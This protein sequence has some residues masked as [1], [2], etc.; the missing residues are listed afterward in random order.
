MHIV[1][2]P[3]LCP[4]TFW[5]LAFVWSVIQGCAGRWYGLYIYDSNAIDKYVRPKYVRHFAYG[6]HHGAFYFLCSFAGFIAWCLAAQFAA[7][8]GETEGAWLTISGGSGTIL[9][10]LAVLGLLGVSGALPRVLYL[11]NRPV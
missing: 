11:G 3:M 4:K 7:K 10:A 9:L 6:F 5:G 2:F 1:S 8:I